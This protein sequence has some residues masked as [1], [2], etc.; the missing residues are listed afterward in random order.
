[1]NITQEKL[2]CFNKVGTYD[3]DI[4][5]A[6]SG[7]GLNVYSKRESVRSY[8]LLVYVTTELCGASFMRPHQ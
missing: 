7:V 5:S 8:V 6:N 3:V 2:D 1:M 4:T